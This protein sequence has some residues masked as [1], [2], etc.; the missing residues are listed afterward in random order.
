MR[1]VAQS[2]KIA[3]FFV[4]NERVKCGLALSAAQALRNR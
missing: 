2:A 3:G 1:N 4:E